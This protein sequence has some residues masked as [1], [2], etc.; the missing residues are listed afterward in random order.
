MSGF[1]VFIDPGHGGKD[2]GTC[3]NGLQEKNIVLDL[4]M[5]LAK[6]LENYNC[7][8]MLSRHKDVYVDNGDRAKA[9]NAWGADLYFSIHVNGHT[10][11]NANGY[12]DFTYL[13]VPPETTD[14]RKAVHTKL[15]S[16]WFNAG[17]A[18]RGMKTA[19]FQVLRETRM[20]AVLV[21]NGFITNPQDAELLKQESFRQDLAEAMAAGIAD[22][23]NL[24]TKVQEDDG[25]KLLRKEVKE[26]RRELA[27]TIQEMEGLRDKLNQIRAIIFE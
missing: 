27:K 17:R 8:I 23:L 9:A 18:N 14:I 20:S 2:P 1:R 3:G 26:L 12:E 13:S 16:V 10:N 6:A 4:A 15:S 19:N 11:I 25:T 22:A 21:E 24:E 5:R 7:Q